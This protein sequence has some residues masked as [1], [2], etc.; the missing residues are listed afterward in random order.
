[1]NVMDK[2]RILFVIGFRWI[3]FNGVSDYIVFKFGICLVVLLKLKFE[4]MKVS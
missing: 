4:I 1:M 3:F 2:K